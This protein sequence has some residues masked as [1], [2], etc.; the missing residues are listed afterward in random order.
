MISARFL[1]AGVY[2]QASEECRPLFAALLGWTG[3]VTGVFEWLLT[4][5]AIA[6]AFGGELMDRTDI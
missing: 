4:G 3:R 1:P 2:W 5:G 6:I